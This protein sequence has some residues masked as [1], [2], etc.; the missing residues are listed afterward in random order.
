MIDVELDNLI[1]ATVRRWGRKGMNEAIVWTVL[2]GTV[3]ELTPDQCAASVHRLVEARR[4]YRAPTRT[5][6]YLKVAISCVATVT[7]ADI[8]ATLWDPGP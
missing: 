3:P 1:W 7:D 6:V 2:S 5:R 4:M 8:P